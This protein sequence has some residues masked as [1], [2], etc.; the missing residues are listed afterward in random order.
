MATSYSIIHMYHKVSFLSEWT[1]RSLGCF[2]F[3]SSWAFFC[4]CFLLLKAMLQQMPWTL[5]FRDFH[6]ISW[7]T[8]RGRNMQ[9]KDYS[10]RRFVAPSAAASSCWVAHPFTALPTVPEAQSF[11]YTYANI[12]T[13]L[14]N[15]Y[16]PNKKEKK[17]FKFAFHFVFHMRINQQCTTETQSSQILQNT[18]WFNFRKLFNSTLNL[19]SITYG[20]SEFQID[21]S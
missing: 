2:W 18:L 12:I 3:C 5:T 19:N 16:Q 1:F 9:E 15:F 11:P 7:R 10:G 17:L 13:N 4:F 14:L 21:V 8:W 6:Y 20:V